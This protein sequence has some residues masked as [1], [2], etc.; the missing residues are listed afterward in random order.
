MTWS[1]N[2]GEHEGA[3]LSMF[4]DGALS[5][6]YGPAGRVAVSEYADGTHAEVDADVRR[7]D[8]AW[9]GRRGARAGGA[10]RDRSRACAYRSLRTAPTRSRSRIPRLLPVGLRTRCTP[11]GRST[12][13]PTTRR[14]PS[15]G[16]K[17]P[18]Q[19]LT[20][21][22]TARAG[23][24]GHVETEARRGIVLALVARL[25]PLVDQI[26]QPIREIGHAVRGHPDGPSFLSFF[27]RPDERPANASHR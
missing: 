15:R 25:R 17:S 4:A 26:A 1:T 21:L 14:V 24:P 11:S 12:S 13:P 3:A 22:W 9:G 8:D 16:S 19:P 23:A 7:E 18:D 2:D 10:A 20:K 6:S 27:R 5:G